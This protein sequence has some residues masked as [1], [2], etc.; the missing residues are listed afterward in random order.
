MK[1]AFPTLLGKEG[2]VAPAVT[3][4]MPARCATGP[5][6]KASVESLRPPR[7]TTCLALI[8]LLTARTAVV[9]LLRLSSATSCSRR[10]KRPPRAL[11]S[12]A[13]RRIP[14]RPGEPMDAS[15][16]LSL[17]GAD[18]YRVSSRRGIAV[19][20]ATRQDDCRCDD[21]RDASK[22]QQ[23]S[24]PRSVLICSRCPLGRL[25]PVGTSLRF[26]PLR[27]GSGGGGR[28]YA[29]EGGRADA[30]RLARQAQ[31]MAE[32]TRAFLS[33][34]GLRAGWACLD[35]GCGDGQ[36]T[37]ELARAVGPTGRAVGI[38]ID[39]QAL[40]I[41]R[42]AARR[43]GLRSE[44]IRADATEP[45]AREAFDLA[46]ARLLLSHLTDP[47]AA[48]RAMRSAVRAGG[49]VA[50]EDLFTGTLR[51]EPPAPALDRLQDVY[52]ATGRAR[53]GDPTIGP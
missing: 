43:A 17:N 30:D 51:S 13:A 11:I 8:K 34:L 19:G 37:L 27:S 9:G 31:V 21:C 5:A 42:R 3:K 33:R 44:F 15:P 14:A 49:W 7:A 6:A 20:A 45:P 1:N 29:I 12:A 25:P 4:G 38:D 52:C 46:Y 26:A 22:R 16:P 40:A 10:P 47:S 39:D 50:V 36:V 41:A 2:R 23:S 28:G 32:A 18:P 24:A 35:V 53:G 48:L